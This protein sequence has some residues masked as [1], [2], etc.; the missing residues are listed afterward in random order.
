MMW[1]ADITVLLFFPIFLDLS[2]FS[3]MDSIQF[4][5]LLLDKPEKRV[6]DFQDMCSL[7]HIIMILVNHALVERA[8]FSLIIFSLM[9][10]FG[11][12]GRLCQ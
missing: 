4:A 1:V 6:F 12:S 8:S 11:R 5:D 10:L 7:Q 3:N 9:T 2:G